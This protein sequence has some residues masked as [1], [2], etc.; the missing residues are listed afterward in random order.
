MI[1]MEAKAIWEILPNIYAEAVSSM[2]YH[3]I[4]FIICY[5]GEFLMLRI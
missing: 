5:F 3:D 4:V 2:M 1:I